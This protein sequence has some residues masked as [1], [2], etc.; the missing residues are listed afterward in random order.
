MITCIFCEL[1]YRKVRNPNICHTWVWW[2]FHSNLCLPRWKIGVG[3]A[4]IVCQY[5]IPS[6]CNTG[7]CLSRWYKS[8]KYMC[9]CIIT[10]YG[11]NKLCTWWHSVPLRAVKCKNLRSMSLWP[12]SSEVKL[13]N[14][15]CLLLH[16]HPLLNRD[17]VP[18]AHITIISGRNRHG[19]TKFFT[20]SYIATKLYY[21]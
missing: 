16:Q 20:K 13:I 21:L 5:Y 9:I 15:M 6:V 2:I 14:P 11:T 10:C 18:I 7:N 19:G 4:D 17:A 12:S 3:R 8:V 1:S